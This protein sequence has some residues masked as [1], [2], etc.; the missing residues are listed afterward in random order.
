MSETP[1]LVVSESL[2]AL[3][4][5]VQQLIT[6]LGGNSDVI[7]LP[8]DKPTIT[9][10]EIHAFI[11][12]AGRT[13]FG[14]ERLAIIPAAH[15][16]SLPAANALLKS[17]EEP[18]R[19]TKFIL[20]THLP[21]QLLPTIRSRCHVVRIAGNTSQTQTFILKD[22]LSQRRPLTDEELASIAQLLQ[23]KL[24]QTGSS[25]EL[26]RGYLRLRDYYKIKSVRGNQ[27]LAAD[28]LLASLVGL[29]N[30]GNK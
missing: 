8:Q 7:Q 11:S 18:G 22:L 27:K 24:Q 10:K 6:K 26:T 20:T 3:D 15:R 21:K 5:H 4:D 17:L 16:L 1:V 14:E 23:T 12:Q 13:A 9:I 2:T 29:G 28:V 19:Q 25:G 30:N